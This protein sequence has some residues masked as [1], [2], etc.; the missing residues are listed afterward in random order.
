MTCKM[1]ALVIGN[2]AYPGSAALKNAANDAKDIGAK[3]R[4]YGF[5]VILITEASRGD[6]GKAL[7]VFR[8]QLKDKE[9]GLFFFAGHGMQIDGSNYL[10]A[11]DTDIDDETD[12]KHSSLSL[13]HVIEVLDKSPASTKIVV[14]DA[15]RDNPWERAWKR[16]QYVRGLASVYAPKGTIIG[17]AT[18]PGQYAY[19][20]GGKNGSYTA[21][22]LQHIDEPD[23]PIET[24]FKQVRNTVAAETTGKQI[25]WE[26]TSLS[27][28]FFFNMSLGRVLQDYP[29]A[30]LADAL[31]VVDTAKASH[32]VVQGLKTYNFTAQ[33]KALE[34]L[35]A[36]TVLKMNPHNLFVVGRNVYQAACGGAYSAEGCVKDFLSATAGYPK[37]GRK[38][39]LDGMLF[40]VFFD[41]HARL[42]NEIKGKFFEEL[43]DLQKLTEFKDSFN[44]LSE[45]LVAAGGDFHSVP[46]RN[47]N[48]AVSVGAKSVGA[49]YRV[50]SVY[51]GGADVLHSVDDE[52]AADHPDKRTYGDYSSERLERLLSKQLLVPARNLRITVTPAEAAGGKLLFPIGYSVRKR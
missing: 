31:F 33:N 1:T 44:F 39:I 9:V 45:A 2:A 5:D 17:F 43:F 19:D 50:E 21:A 6:M 42:R 49:Q 30:S 51:I 26:H 48:L 16:S 18:S 22:L 13:D 23:L 36:T 27:G 47:H 32:L 34:G 8:D 37:G 15:C 29:D 3:L 4:K 10:M 12:A 25:S 41:K 20:G 46:G 40:E 35:T 14:L 11:L 38:A 52:L 28:N 24:M 7:K